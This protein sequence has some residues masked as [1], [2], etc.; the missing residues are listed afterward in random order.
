MEHPGAAG[1]GEVVTRRGSEV[2]EAEAEAILN[3]L[4][5]KQPAYILNWV[6]RMTRCT[7]ARVADG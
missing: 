3:E 7:L 5:P 6:G 2:V 1:S 4:G